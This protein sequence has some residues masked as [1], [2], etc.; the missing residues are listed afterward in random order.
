MLRQGGERLARALPDWA[1]SIRFRLTAL[2]SLFLFSLAALVIGGIYIGLDHRLHQQGAVSRQ[3]VVVREEPVPGGVI[4]RRETVSARYKSVEQLANERALALLRTYSSAALALLFLASLGVGWLVAGRV[5]QPIDRIAG[6]ARDIQATDL[7]RRIALVGPP[8]ELKELADTFDAMLGRL[9]EAFEGQR[10]FVQETSHELRNPLAVMRTNLEVAL[11]D[12]AASEADLRRTANLVLSTVERL[13]DIVDNLLAH[14][15]R[16]GGALRELA[17]VEVGSVVD[18]VIAEFT[19]PAAARNL[20][21]EG[22]ARAPLPVLADRVALRQALANLVDNAV[23]LAPERTS[24]RVTAG[25]D[26]GW[27]WMTV[28]DEGPG[29]PSHEQELVF[30]RS[31]RG[32]PAAGAEPG[33]S[34]L[35]L[36][37]V[38]QIAESHGGLA[39]LSPSASGGSVFAIWL[40]ALKDTDASET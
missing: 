32:E 39:A 28:E 19:A 37:I 4:L 10:Q 22:S 33:R 3:F 25:S 30:R 35:G 24:I 11:A 34:G 31:W 29:V 38:R 5:L 16:Q 36:A 8:D 6:V 2:Y 7:S 18:D 13:S 40:P 14:A 9:D 23:R 15:R 20:R 27:V 12:P 26:A 17:P 1:G 21:L